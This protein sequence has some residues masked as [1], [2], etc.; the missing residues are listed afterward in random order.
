MSIQAIA[1]DVSKAYAPL[2]NEIHERVAE[3]ETPVDTPPE[4]SFNSDPQTPQ[5]K[6]Q[7][8]KLSRFD[9]DEC[10]TH[11]I[12]ASENA[13][14][15][16][17]IMVKTLIAVVATALI[18]AIAVL[19]FCAPIWIPILIGAVVLTAGVRAYRKS[20]EPY[21][22]ATAEIA[23]QLMA[24]TIEH[25]RETI[26]RLS[27]SGVIQPNKS[28]KFLEAL[29]TVYRQPEIIKAFSNATLF[30]D[31]MNTDSHIEAIE[32]SVNESVKA[33]LNADA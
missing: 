3:L 30:C 4:E 21:Y 12:A 15:M 18:G 5:A 10:K 31:L 27:C 13:K 19:A 9:L 23:K 29:I 17:Q 25:Y 8:R 20:G 28:K 6:L 2:R 11:F 14:K 32:K 1:N 16:R 26:A 7:Y 22:E 24:K 33:I